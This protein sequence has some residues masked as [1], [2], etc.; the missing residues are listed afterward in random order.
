MEQLGCQADSRAAGVAPR[1]VLL[2]AAGQSR[3]QDCSQEL[4]VRRRLQQVFVCLSHALTPHQ[5]RQQ[6]ILT[7]ALKERHL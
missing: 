2:E 3:V 6:L 4:E 7:K 1:L 5:S